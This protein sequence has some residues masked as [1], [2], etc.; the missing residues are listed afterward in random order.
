MK[1]LGAGPGRWFRSLL[2]L[3]KVEREAAERGIE[4]GWS[5][6]NGGCPVLATTSRQKTPFGSMRRLMLMTRGSGTST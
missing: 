1:M 5:Y 3:W 4:S 2:F 6:L